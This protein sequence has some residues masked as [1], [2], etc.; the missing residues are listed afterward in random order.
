VPD[1]EEFLVESELLRDED[2]AVIRLSSPNVEVIIRVAK[3]MSAGGELGAI[4]QNL[5]QLTDKLFKGAVEEKMADITPE[6][7]QA[8]ELARIGGNEAAQR[9]LDRHKNGEFSAQD[10]HR[11]QDREAPGAGH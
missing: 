4:M 3:N 6:Q 1:E 8:L 7:L 2:H 10:H 11:D 5:P 9:L